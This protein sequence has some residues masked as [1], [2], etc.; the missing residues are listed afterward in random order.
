MGDNEVAFR[1]KPEYV[2][3][4]VRVEDRR[5]AD[6]GYQR[7]HRDNVRGMDVQDDEVAPP[8]VPS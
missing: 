1:T 4:V 5:Q 2:I 8:Q 7:Q 3:R 6:P